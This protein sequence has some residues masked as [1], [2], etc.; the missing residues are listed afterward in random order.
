MIASLGADG[1]YYPFGRLDDG[2]TYGYM[3]PD[4]IKVEAGV[5]A[6]A[7]A[8]DFIITLEATEA[9]FNIKNVLGQYFY[10]S[11]NYDSFNVTTEVGTEGYDWTVTSAGGAD[12]F[13]ITNV[14]KE[15]SVKLNYYVNKEGVAQYSFG[16]YAASKVNDKTYYIQFLIGRYGWLYFL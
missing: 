4:P 12:L 16:S 6:V 3:Y 8:A 2:K 5:I 1:Q 9:G 15:K 7:D 13:T 11:G 14:Q 10:M